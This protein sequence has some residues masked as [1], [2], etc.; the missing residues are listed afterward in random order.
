MQFIV[1]RSPDVV[2]GSGRLVVGCVCKHTTT[3]RAPG[4][5]RVSHGHA[6]GAPV[7]G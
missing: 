1:S 2:A 3:A 4:G 7:P 5:V 6:R